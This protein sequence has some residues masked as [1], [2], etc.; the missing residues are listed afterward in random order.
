MNITE[1][2]SFKRNY[3]IVTPCKN[4]SVNLP[5]IIKSIVNQ[6][7]KPLLW[8]IVDDGSIDDTQTILMR[9]IKEYNWIHVIRLNEGKRDLG[10]HYAKIVQ[11]GFDE[12][13]KICKQR[14]YEIDFFGVVDADIILEGIFFEIFLKEFEKDDTLGIVSGS[15]KHII[16]SRIYHAK[17]NVNEP[18]GGHMLI[19][20]MCFEEC[21]GFP[22]VTYVPDSVL[23]AKAR[24][25]EWKTKRI[26][27]NIAIEIRDVNSAEGYWKGY[28]NK[29]KSYYYLNFNPIQVFVK[30]INY[31]F[32]NPY[33]LGIAY[34]IGYFSSFIKKEKKI[35]D[36]KIKEYYWNKWRTKFKEKL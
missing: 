5:N 25:R 9:A 34:F 32:K 23:R 18:S 3:I 35:E 13:I 2:N 1:P 22:L 16:G 7:I 8:V 12:G 15:T 31:S 20:K 4:E 33:Y 21:G 24:L 19:R 26:I 27:E 6:T 14:K 28:F 10:F 11:L 29:G 30:I 17:G 36:S